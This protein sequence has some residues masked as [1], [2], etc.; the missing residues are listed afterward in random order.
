MAEEMK[1]YTARCHCQAV[2]Y[3]VTIPPLETG[4]TEVMQCNCSIC[5]KRGYATVYPRHE[6]VKWLKGWD[7]LKDYYFGNKTRPHKFCG[8]CGTPVGID[9][10]NVDIP[11]L[12]GRLGLT[13]SIARE[14][15]VQPLG[16]SNEHYR[17]EH[18]MESRT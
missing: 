15:R 1:T 8:E 2:I 4:A 12:K 9:F 17:C 7:Q 13:V 14:D 16:K 18:S 5:T 6:E 11:R 3:L 10:A